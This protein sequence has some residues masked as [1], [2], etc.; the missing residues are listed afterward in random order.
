MEKWLN[1]YRDCRDVWVEACFRSIYESPLVE[2]LAGLHEAGLKSAHK[3]HSELRN[4]LIAMKTA[5]IEGRMTKGRFNDALARVLMYQQ[6]GSH[7]V[8]EERGFRLLQSLREQLPEADRPSLDEVKHAFK[9]AASM[10]AIDPERVIASLL[11]VLPDAA[12]RNR[13]VEM[14][15]NMVAARGNVEA[16]REN[17][18]RHVAEVL[19]VEPGA[20]SPSPSARGAKKRAVAEPS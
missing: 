12:D 9:D 1:L 10:V 3:P 6:I 19:G 18:L 17:R 2:S 4:A 8:A 11:Q 15:W 20:V 14:A 5:E 7:F 13:L 16:E